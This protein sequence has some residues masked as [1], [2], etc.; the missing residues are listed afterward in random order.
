MTR[1]SPESIT[2]S[3]HQAAIN[4]WFSRL[5]QQP[6]AMLLSSAG[7]SHPDA[8]YDILT[9]D[10]LI[11]LTTRG[12]ETIITED[13]DDRLSREDPL[14]LVEQALS[15]LSPVTQQSYPFCGGAVGSMGLRFRASFR[16]NLEYCSG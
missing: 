12:D 4:T 14:S 15:C 9:A 10:P 5:E 8:R 13:G 11:T 7:A 2:L 3:Y 6:W 16:K 1:K